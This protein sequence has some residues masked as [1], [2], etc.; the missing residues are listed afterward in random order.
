VRN[1]RTSASIFG[2]GREDERRTI[3]SVSD[4]A[5]GGVVAERLPAVCR[6]VGVVAV[7]KASGAMSAAL[8]TI[9]GV[10]V[11]LIIWWLVFDGD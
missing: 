2:W 3:H 7:R 11:A 9:Y 4:P 1:W 10:A 5:G 8:G 6:G